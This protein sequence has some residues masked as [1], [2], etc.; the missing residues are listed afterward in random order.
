MFH[1]Q[2]QWEKEQGFTTCMIFRSYVWKIHLKLFLV[3][4]VQT[5]MNADITSE[6]SFLLKLLHT[7]YKEEKTK[8]LELWPLQFSVSNVI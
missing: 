3:F 4:D 5:L 2:S 7:V 1:C 6:S 8:K